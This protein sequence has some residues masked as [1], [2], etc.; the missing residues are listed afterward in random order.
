MT[1][2]TRP[3]APRLGKEECKA[4]YERANAAGHAAAQ[5]CVPEPMYVQRTDG[6]VYPP[7]M[8]GV[9]GFAWVN[10]KPGNSAFAR[11]VKDNVHGGRS[12]SYYGGVSLWV[13]GYGQSY[14]QKLAYARGFV[15][16][17]EEVGIRAY[18]MSRLD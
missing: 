15:G 10:I 13:A 5:A 2:A 12:D 8:G 4:L 16:V 9:C 7:I 6:Y 18:A 11:Y 14:E 1:T 17:L 3:K